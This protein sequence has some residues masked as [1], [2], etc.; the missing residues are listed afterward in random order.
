MS[1]YWN[2]INGYFEVDQSNPGL[3]NYDDIHNN[4]D[5][6]PNVPDHPEMAAIADAKST[7]N[8]EFSV[9]PIKAPEEK[10]EILSIAEE[11][12]LP[13]G[14]V[15]EEK[16]E[17]PE[18]EKE[19][20]MTKAY[21]MPGYVEP[22]DER[23][24]PPHIRNF[25]DYIATIGDFSKH[26]YEKET[27]APDSSEFAPD[28]SSFAPDSSSFA[29][30]SSSFAPDSSSFSNHNNGASYKPSNG[31][32]RPKKTDYKPN[33]GSYKPNNASSYRPDVGSFKP[34]GT[35]SYRP[36]APQMGGYRQNRPS[37]ASSYGGSY[38]AP[39]GFGSLSSI[40]DW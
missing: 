6:S 15:E 30:D 28:S 39:T 1:Q 27:Y 26:G 12:G 10:K 17:K 2:D 24:Y 11:H 8:S 31:G 4:V 40:A 32:Y 3:P 35:S 37:G 34:S 21:Y 36:A 22:A 14:V 38:K 13:P 25:K 7:L 19:A 23:E 18:L 29:P 20:Y 5:Y 16:E 33:A 9:A